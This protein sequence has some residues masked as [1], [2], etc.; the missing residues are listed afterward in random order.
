MSSTSSVS[1]RIAVSVFSVAASAV[2]FNLAILVSLG[3]TAGSARALVVVATVAVLAAAGFAFVSLK[4]A[5]LVPMGAIIDRASKLSRNCIAGIERIAAGMARGDLTGKLEATTSPINVTSDDEFGELARTV[6]GIIAT[7]QASIA[8]LNA[9]QRNVL[10][11]VTDAGRLNAAAADGDLSQRADT[12]RYQGSYSELASGIN[13]LMDSV[14]VPIRDASSVLQKLADRNLT[15]RMAGAYRGEFV[16]MQDALNA[17]VTNLDQALA[18][19]AAAAEQVAGAGG[20]ISAGSDGLAHGAADQAASLEETTSSLTELASMAKLN[21]QNAAQARAL[22]GSARDIATLGVQEMTQ[23]SQAMDQ[24]TKSSA[25]TAKIVKTIDEIAF[26]T[27]LLALNAAVEAARAGDAGKGFAVVAEEVRSLAIRSAEAAKNTASLIDE[28]V[29][30]AQSGNTFTHVVNGKLLEINT[31]VQN[32]GE[33][34]GE[35]ANTSASQSD[36][37]QQLTSAASQMNATTQTVAS[38]AEEAASAA[39]ELSSQA[40][41]LQDLVNSFV[42]TNGR[43]ARTPHTTRV[44]H[45]PRAITKAPAAVPRKAPLP[46]PVPAPKRLASRPPIKAAPVPIAKPAPRDSGEALIPFDDGDDESILSVF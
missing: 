17:A 7:C 11:I 32:L 28:S 29:R 31:Q 37:V 46:S 35:I 42:I 4:R 12:S 36:G 16:G 19:V 13:H 34:I 10:A 8:S 43:P 6:N 40:Q 41:T 45:T 18:E 1:R 5:I 22:A 20:E 25:E 9:A 33:V 39:V 27:N 30:H 24:I 2:A 23:L 21:A 38:N 3:E 44:A 14:S 15:A 26:Q